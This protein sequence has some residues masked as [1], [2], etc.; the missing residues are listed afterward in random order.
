MSDFER[1]RDLARLS[2]VD[3]A[4][5]GAGMLAL[6]PAMPVRWMA[7]AAAV[8][9]GVLLAY[10][11]PVLAGQGAELPPPMAAAGVQLGANVLAAGLA[12]QVGRWFG[13][14]GGFADALLLVAWLQGLM[15]LV[16]LVQL[17][18]FLVLPFAGGLVV[19]LAL[20]LF[21]WLVVGFVQAL[22]GFA[23]PLLV[24]AGTF[25]TLFAAAFVISFVL[26]LFGFDP[27]GMTDA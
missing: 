19:I 4:R 1:L 23:S 15:V 18:V 14:Q 2:L 16:Q 12:A 8:L 9:V 20:G 3:P 25:A 6:N 5:G 26:I 17:L 22:H 21:F 27:R 11:L 7:M 13:G 24:L 10:V